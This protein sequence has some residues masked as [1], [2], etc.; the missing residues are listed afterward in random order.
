MVGLLERVRRPAGGAGDRECRRVEVGQQADPVQHDRGVVLDV[1]LQRP[2]GLVLGQQPQRHV[3]DVDR[4]LQPVGVGRQP[5]R[6]LPQR[7]GPRI[8]RL[9][10]TVTEAHQP[11]ATGQ[12]LADP[13]LGVLDV[14]DLGQLVAHL[15]RRTAVQPPLERAHRT[16]DGAGQVAL[17]A[18][19]D[20]GGEG[21]CVQ[22]VL[23]TDGEV[24]VQRARLGGVGLLAA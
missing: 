18:G 13:D 16:A 23:G 12:R 6:H 1:G 14:A 5:L 17:R 4:Q 3:L 21:G 24:G 20:A 2:V 15:R 19:D 11:L 9:V 10:D 22:A 7:R 8:H